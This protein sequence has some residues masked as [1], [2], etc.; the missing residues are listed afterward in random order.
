MKIYLDVSCLNRPFDDQSQIRIRRESEA[1][2]LILDGMEAGRWEQV[3]SR[4][5]E[6]ELAAIADETRRRRMFQLL[7]EARFG[8]SRPIFDRARRL[9]ELGLGTADA[10]YVAGAE[11][12]QAGVLLTCDDRLLRRCR[13]LAEQLHGKV[14]NPSEWLQEQNDATNFG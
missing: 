14:A 4:M 3:P 10:V 8:L 1:L 7:P 13:Q 6:I 11:F 5:A 9:V 12:L 2:T